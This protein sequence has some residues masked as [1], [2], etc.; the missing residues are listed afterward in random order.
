[1]RND[2]KL[3]ADSRGHWKRPCLID[4][5]DI[6]RWTLK[7]VRDKK[8]LRGLTAQKFTRHMNDVILIKAFG[9]DEIESF[10]EKIEKLKKELKFWH[11]EYPISESTC[12]RQMHDLK[13]GMFISSIFKSFLLTKCFLHTGRES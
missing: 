12:L 13:R 5:E 7:F 11:L 4:E 9:C 8:N 3:L 1:M 2:G 10:S 6:R